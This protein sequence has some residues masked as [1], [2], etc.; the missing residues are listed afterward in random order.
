[1]LLSLL[2]REALTTKLK[3]AI[4]TFAPMWHGEDISLEYY[5][6]ELLDL[7]SDDEIPLDTDNLPAATPLEQK[8]IILRRQLNKILTLEY[9]EHFDKPF[10]DRIFDL[11]ILLARA[12][13]TNTKID[14]NTWEDPLHSDMHFNFTTSDLIAFSNGVILPTE[15]AQQ[16]YDNDTG[17]DQSGRP[18]DINNKVLSIRELKSLENQGIVIDLLRQPKTNW[19]STIGTLAGN[20]IGMG[21]AIAG[22]FFFP[23]LPILYG[24]AFGLGFL[25]YA[26]NDNSLG[27]FKGFLAGYGII[28]LFGGLLSVG[29][30]PLLTLLVAKS[31]ISAAAAA[32]IGTFVK[33][34][35]LP[36]LFPAIT[37]AI[38]IAK[39]YLSNESLALSFYKI[40]DAFFHKIPVAI[41]TW[42]ADKVNKIYRSCVPTASQT[43]RQNQ[44][45]DAPT[46]AEAAQQGN[47]TTLIASM[48]ITP[49][50]CT[51]APIAAASSIA[52]KSDPILTPTVENN[53]ENGYQALRL[54][55]G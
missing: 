13:P 20:I 16:Y 35:A 4:I 28:F 49:A 42:I 14:E 1:M 10:C 43:T 25:A 11:Q 17:Y 8:I 22:A 54:S 55:G 40:V 5:L 2:S 45:V 30:P 3:D 29:F 9:T 41:C 27:D 52:D 39:S 15:L 7:L 33:T 23:P 24:T 32:T 50:I 44:N 18:R 36:Y 53:V 47:S 48:G 26:Y 21:L 31:V 37:L 19:T 38:G 6:D 51:V 12:F 46:T 34:V